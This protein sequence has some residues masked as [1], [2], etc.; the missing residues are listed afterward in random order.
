MTP[1]Y[2]LLD[3]IACVAV[4]GADAQSFLQAQLSFDVANLTSGHAPLVG[5]H[6]PKGRV[7]ALFR[8]LRQADRWVLMTPRDMLDTL[9]PRL[10]MYVLRAAVN[11]AS[12]PDLQAAAVLDADEW[13]NARGVG[14]LDVGTVAAHDGLDWIRVGPG[15]VHVVGTA[16]AIATAVRALD[17]APREHAELAEIK[18]GLPAVTHA[19]TERFV[20]QMLN[21]DRLGAI[22][23]TKGC[24]PGQEVIA[25]VHNLGSVKR[26]MRRYSARGAQVPSAGAEVIRADGTAVGEVVRAAPDADRIELLAVVEHEAA[27]AALTIAPNTT[28]VLE[29]LPYDVP[30]R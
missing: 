18:L 15:L 30:A 1:R 2:C 19:L 20:A 9:L 10:S 22:S 5:W 17:T 26:R 16:G 6:D 29:P 25:R 21:L 27:A 7:R 23:F 8:V 14:N 3:R 24:Y 4:H 11:V 28:L 13:V 12:A